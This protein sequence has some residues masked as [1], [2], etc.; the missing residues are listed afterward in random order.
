L[1][2]QALSNYEIL[3]GA[4]ES[5]LDGLTSI[6]AQICDAPETGSVILDSFL[7]YKLEAEVELTAVLRKANRF[8]LKEALAGILW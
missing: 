4:P 3:D 5:A 1:R 8:N 2:L 6:A 7:K